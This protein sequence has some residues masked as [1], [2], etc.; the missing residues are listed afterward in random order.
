MEIKKGVSAIGLKPE[1][2]LALTIATFVYQ[3]FQKVLVVT[4]GVEAK[5]SLGSL[6]YVG[7]A[8]DIRTNY[9]SKAQVPRVV[10]KLKQALGSE[11]DVVLKKDCIHIEFQPKHGINLV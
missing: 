7:Y 2:I 8:A 9:F 6:H 1:I 4:S 3:R 5:H 11:Y 10:Y